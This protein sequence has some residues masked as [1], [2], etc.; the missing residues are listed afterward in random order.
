[1]VG[2]VHA[3]RIDI[4]KL[5][6]AERTGSTVYSAIEPC[7]DI[8]Q[9][10]EIGPCAVLKIESGSQRVGIGVLD[11]YGKFYSHRCRNPLKNDFSVSVFGRKLREA[12]EEETFEYE[13]VQKIV[14]SGKRRVAVVGSGT[15]IYVQ[16][17]ISDLRSLPIRRSTL[18]HQRGCV[19]LLRNNGA[20]KVAAGASRFGDFTDADVFRFRSILRG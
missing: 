5:Q 12:I 1:V 4:E 7:I 8:H 6:I 16:F 17:S 9:D 18:Q 19:D 15:N 2:R 11:L 13:N 3:E 14:G 10:Q 20:I